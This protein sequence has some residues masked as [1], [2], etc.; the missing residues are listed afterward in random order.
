MEN[1]IGEVFK[2]ISDRLIIMKYV[3]DGNS[4]ENPKKTKKSVPKIAIKN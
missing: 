4:C 3:L 2:L 1:G